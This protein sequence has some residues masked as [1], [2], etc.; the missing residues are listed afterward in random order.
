MN[1]TQ[2]F[3]FAR[4]RRCTATPMAARHRRTEDGRGNGS[5]PARGRRRGTTAMGEWRWH[6]VAR[7]RRGARRLTGGTRSSVISEL[8]FTPDKNSSK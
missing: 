7:A 2:I 8:K 5:S 3:E 4:R 1:P 6:A